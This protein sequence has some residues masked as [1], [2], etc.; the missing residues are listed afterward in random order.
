M[1]RIVEVLLIQA[2]PGALLVPVM[3]VGRKA[4]C[5]T[6]REVSFA[7]SEDVIAKSA[8]IA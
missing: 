7:E 8:I 2:R 6:T 5:L 3:L 4:G 1:N